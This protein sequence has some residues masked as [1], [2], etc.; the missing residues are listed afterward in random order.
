MN[1]LYIEATRSTPQIDFNP[2]KDFLSIKG[3]S[4]PENAFKFYDPIFEWLKEYFEDAK[5]RAFIIEF[6][7]TYLNTSSTKSIMCILDMLED[8]YKKNRKIILNWYYY[9]DDEFS[10]EIAENFMED[11]HIPFNLIV[12]EAE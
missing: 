4:Y 1:R 3:E 8:L 7:I 6:D 2:E 9:N 12:K 11:L 10:Y 5:E